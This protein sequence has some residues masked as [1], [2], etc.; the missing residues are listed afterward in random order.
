MFPGS[1]S[2]WKTDSSANRGR[3]GAAF[4]SQPGTTGPLRARNQSGIAQSNSY[5]VTDGSSQRQIGR[6]SCRERV[7]M[8]EVDVVLDRKEGG[9]GMGGGVA[10]E[11]YHGALG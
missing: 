8:W 3:D 11:G 4:F 9:G 7:V 2:Q 6:A 10:V 1:G 5:P